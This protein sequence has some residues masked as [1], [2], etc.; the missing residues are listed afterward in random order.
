MAQ[1]KITECPRDAMQGIKKWIHTEDKIGYL[2]NLLKVGFDT[3]DCGSFV[4]SKFIPQLKDTG[5]VVRS[6]DLSSTKTK[7]LVIIANLR[8]AEIACNYDIA[9]GM[10]SSSLCTM[11]SECE[12]IIVY[13]LKSII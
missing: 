8:G 9:V 6:L 7:L 3:L 11:K 4:S 12:K 10:L 1:I 13:C 2:Q 5:E